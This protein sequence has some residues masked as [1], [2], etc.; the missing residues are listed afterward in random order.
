MK[1]KTK[2]VRETSHW[3]SNE[4][5]LVVFEKNCLSFG[6]SWMSLIGNQEAAAAVS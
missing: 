5:D 6:G 3:S 1:R 4:A 2:V